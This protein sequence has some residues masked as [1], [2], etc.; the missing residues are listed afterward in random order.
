VDGPPVGPRRC[1]ALGG[2]DGMAPSARPNQPAE[3]ATAAG[4]AHTAVSPAA[5]GVTAGLKVSV[6]V[7]I[8]HLN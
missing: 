3:P 7:V 1:A 4:R 5:A 8:A 6:G 2:E